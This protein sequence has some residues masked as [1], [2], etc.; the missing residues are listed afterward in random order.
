MA[1]FN[2]PTS[3]TAHTTS[4]VQSASSTPDTTTHEGGYGYSRDAR[5]E[6]FLLGVSLFANEARSSFYESAH[7]R[8]ERFVMLVR[9]LA[10]SAD[11]TDQHWV[12]NFLTW[13][14]NEGNI[15]TA[16]LLGTV[17]F[18]H[19]RSSWSTLPHLVPHLS[20][21]LAS[22]I[23][24]RP[25]EPGELLA[26]HAQR[27]GRG[28]P[29]AL[30]RGVADAARRHYTEKNW[31]KWDS[32]RAGF[33]FADVL[34]ITHPLPRNERQN[35]LFQHILNT[36]Y[37][38][39]HEV[40]EIPHALPMVAKR[41]QME[42]RAV[43]DRSITLP[44]ITEAGMTW[45][46]AAG[47][48]N[49]S[50]TPNEWATLVPTMGY[51]ALLRNLRNMEQ[52]GID[53]TTV[54]TVNARLQDPD[55]VARSRQLPMRFLSAY[56]ATNSV[57]FD[58]ALSRAL[59]LSLANVPYLDGNTLILVDRSGSMFHTTSAQTHLTYADSAALFGAALYQR[60][61]SADVV[62]FG[63]RSNKLRI[64][65]GESLLTSVRDRF[66]SMGGT[67]TY[68]A[69][70]AHLHRRHTRVVLLT[71]EQAFPGSIG[72][73]RTLDGIIPQD[74]PLYTYNLVGYRAGHTPSGRHNRHT[75]GGLSDASFR[76]IPWVEAASHAQW[77]WLDPS[78][79][80]E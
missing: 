18:V 62:Q 16:A 53:G 7:N 78:S 64:P 49:R 38:G 9:D 72:D 75:F 4:P 6:L 32:R 26:I 67:N 76:L 47:W 33:T 68:G 40:T 11:P 73:P 19:A 21:T 37:E 56:R 29:M 22:Q 46:N 60:A 3:R 48:L 36:A 69:V 27:H 17:E 10:I 14:R 51:M 12:R 79:T 50:L 44:E 43:P 35:I 39:T 13:I 5:S 34:Q 28:W 57:Q 58:L 54:D 20:R 45:E 42:S 52:A 2:T 1:K 66:S 55:E 65:T 70:Q 41:A 63:T 80:S 31:L 15:R 71:D 77:P 74:V 25:D 59:D 8:D 23:A 30:K 61:Q 24:Q